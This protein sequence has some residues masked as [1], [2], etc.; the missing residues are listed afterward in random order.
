[1]DRVG[2]FPEYGVAEL[3]AATGGFHKLCLIGEGGEFGQRHMQGL[4]TGIKKS[5]FI[6]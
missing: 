3:Y 2:D 6:G 1:M 4:V 5:Q